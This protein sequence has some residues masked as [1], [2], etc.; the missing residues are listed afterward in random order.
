[1]G[2]R[3]RGDHP[4]GLERGRIQPEPVEQGDAV[5]EEHGSQVN[6]DLVEQAGLQVL[7]DGTRTAGNGHVLF[8]GSCPS[9][10]E[11]SL[12]AVGRRS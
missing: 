2:D 11:R 6:L 1:M 12:D 3:G 4:R 8:T 10:L 7:L 9:L 5:A